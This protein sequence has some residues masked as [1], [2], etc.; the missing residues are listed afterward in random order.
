MVRNAKQIWLWFTKWFSPI[1]YCM[2]HECTIIK[3]PKQ[4]LNILSSIT[5]PSLRLHLDC[6]QLMVTNTADRPSHE[7]EKH[8]NTIIT[9]KSE[10]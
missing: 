6:K 9:N 7:R 4:R 3:P 5:K 8:T 2:I 10:P 1:R